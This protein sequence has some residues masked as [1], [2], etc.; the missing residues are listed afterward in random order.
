MQ[1]ARVGAVPVDFHRK[2]TAAPEH[3][4]LEAVDPHVRLVPRDTGGAEQLDHLS[5]RGRAGSSPST[6]EVQ[7]LCQR[8]D[9][10][11]AAVCAR[12]AR[13][14]PARWRGAD[15]WP[16]R[17][18]APDPPGRARQLGRGPS[19]AGW[20]GAFPGAGG[21]P[22]GMARRD[23]PQSEASRHPAQSAP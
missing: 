17:R 15:S 3:I 11:L 12:A 23:E 8:P 19:A 1:G 22:V 5:L 6:R 16:R 10:A 4:D 18:D 7:D 13:E 2:V 20:S 21:H 9:S 14:A